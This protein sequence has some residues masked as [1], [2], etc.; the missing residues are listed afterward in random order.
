MLEDNYRRT[1]QMLASWE[2]HHEVENLLKAST[3]YQGGIKEKIVAESSKPELPN[4]DKN[5]IERDIEAL[6]RKES[7]DGCNCNIT[8]GTIGFRDTEA[9][10]LALLN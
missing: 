1:A 8:E 2:G 4:I 5:K 10:G 7:Q 3:N 6:F 9:L